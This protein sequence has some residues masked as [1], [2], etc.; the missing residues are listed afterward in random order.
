MRQSVAGTNAAVSIP[1]LLDTLADER[2]ANQ[3]LKA[4]SLDESDD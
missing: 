4:A 2:E 1:E 3:I